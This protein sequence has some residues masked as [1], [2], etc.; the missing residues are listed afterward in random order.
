MPELEY[1][2]TL[3]PK[4][5]QALALLAEGQS[6]TSVAKACGLHRTTIQYWKRN[7]PE[8][9]YT[10]QD[11][12]LE[13]A[14]FWRAA[15]NQRAEA[16]LALIDTFL[17]DPKVPASVRLKAALH[18]LKAATAPPPPFDYGRHDD[19]Y[20]AG[21]QL[22]A[23]MRG[24]EAERLQYLRDNKDNWKQATAAHRSASSHFI[25][26]DK[27]E[28][29]DTG[30]APLPN[31]QDDS[32][33]FITS[34]KVETKEEATPAPLPAG[35]LISSHFITSHDNDAYKVATIRH[36]EP[37]TGRNQLCPCK[38]GRKFKHCCLDKPKAA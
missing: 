33:H 8:F 5:H 19:P 23:Q 28:K 9:A 38:S 24:D 20:R 1:L 26:S 21:N 13:N 11:A 7:S 34:H 15:S 18:I 6:I 3:T 25:T 2:T 16:A 22:L 31:P 10:L 14:D 12:R 27:A 30:A 37:P 17:A 29:K 35:R 32:S 4:Q 36:P